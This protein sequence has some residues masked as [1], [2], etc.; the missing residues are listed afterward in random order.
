MSLVLRSSLIIVLLLLRISFTYSQHDLVL[1]QR[2]M[3]K[4][5]LSKA[6]MFTHEF[7][8]R[9]SIENG[10]AQMKLLTYRPWIEVKYSVIN[11]IQYSPIAVI[12]RSTEGN[13]LMEWRSSV[14]SNWNFQKEKFTTLTRLGVEA[15]LMGKEINY[16]VRAR[17]GVKYTGRNT[18]LMLTNETLFSASPE[19]VL[20]QNWVHGQVDIHVLQ[21]YKIQFGVQSVQEKRA[22]KGT[23][24]FT[25]IEINV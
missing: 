19:T 24:L 7:H 25:G 17:V 5:N 3:L 10:R 15:R 18:S 21:K 13:Q 14:W 9:E 1:W 11:S 23:I 2:V 4:H 8:A 6:N 12:Y 20:F 22:L 16:R